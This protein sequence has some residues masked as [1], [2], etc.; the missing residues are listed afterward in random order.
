MKFC[1]RIEVAAINPVSG[2]DEGSS[3][4]LFNNRVR[5]AILFSRRQYYGNQILYGRKAWLHLRGILCSVTYRS[6]LMGM[7]VNV[8]LCVNYVKNLGYS[9]GIVS[10]FMNDEL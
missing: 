1:R 3:R 7:Y 4:I 9:A 10:E 5:T 2:S 6:I 8:G